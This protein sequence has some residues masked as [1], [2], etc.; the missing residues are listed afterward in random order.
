VPFITEAGLGTK[1]VVPW[2]VEAHPR[3]REQRADKP[4]HELVTPRVESCLWVLLALVM[5]P[6]VASAQEEGSG[7]WQLD[8]S[9]LQCVPD[10]RSGFECRQ[11]ECLPVCS[12]PCG[13]GLLCTSSGTCVQTAPAAPLPAAP[14]VRSWRAAS[15]Q[16]LPA[17]R[18]GYTCLGGQ[19]VSACN[20]ICPAGEMCTAQGQC[21][22]GR[23]PISS[24]PE[25][26][27]S[28]PN[29]PEKNSSADSIV[30]LHIDVLGS[31]QFG[32]TPTLEIG[33]TVSGYLRLRSFN[34][35]VA[36]YFLLGRDRD[37]ELHW[38]VGAALGMHV[39]L[40]RDGNMRG[41]FG[42][43]SLEYAFVKTRDLKK[44]FAE[45]GTH[46]LV[47]QFDFGNRW[48]FDRFLLGL[49]ARVGLSVPLS[50]FADPIGGSG[51]RRSGSC[52]SQQDL[53]F[54]AGVFLDLG[55]YL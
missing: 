14:A 55:C 28:E 49:G 43:P 16:C 54:V 36:S 7:D 52:D 24:E 37:D 10:C 18:T 2:G 50:T 51:C 31:L 20:P 26:A 30:N 4:L 42:G 38:G 12:P 9:D 33:K 11:G 46:A 17:C 21:I 5:F 45:Y 22:P 6:K 53:S 25:A 35:G 8:P 23:A 1:P 29:Q 47:P 19:C 34:T 40:G 32:L 15:D 27:I 44:D 39:F 3:A 13:P 41:L 48:A